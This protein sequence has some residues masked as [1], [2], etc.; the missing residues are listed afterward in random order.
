MLRRLILLT[1][2]AS[3]A[4]TVTAFQLT[5]PHKHLHLY[6]S[7]TRRESTVP[8]V[9]NR[10]TNGVTQTA[11]FG[12]VEDFL[13]GSDDSS[14][15]KENAKYLEK[16]QNRVDRINALEPK[17]EDL[18]DEELKAKTVEFR[19]RLRKGEDINGPLLEEAFAVVREAAW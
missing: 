8:Y 4:T 17:V 16:L 15:A 19:E 3:S 2:L 18:D 6:A 1:V 11:L 5:R 10:P 12:I 9:F 14:R 13:L 7:Q